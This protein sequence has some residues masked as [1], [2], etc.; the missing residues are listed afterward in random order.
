VSPLASHRSPWEND[1]AWT[2]Q[3]DCAD[4]SRLRQQVYFHL[5]RELPVD[6][7]GRVATD[8]DAAANSATVKMVLDDSAD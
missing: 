1:N 2:I 6:D 5:R 3:R 4:S 7:E 8:I